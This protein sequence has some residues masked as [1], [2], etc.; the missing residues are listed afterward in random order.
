MPAPVRVLVDG[1]LLG[2]PYGF[3]RFAD[4]LCR[5]LGEAPVD[6]VEVTVVVPERLLSSL[7]EYPG[8]RWR[9]APETN[10]VRW[11][12]V[13]LPR[14]ARELRS[15]VLH[16]LY[17]TGPLRPG[18]ATV[19]TVHDLFFLHDRVPVRR[20]KDRIWAEY[21][22]LVFRSAIPRYAQVT[23]V[24][25]ATRRALAEVGIDARTVHNTVDGFVADHPP[26]V[27]P[28]RPRYALHRG[29]AM[30]HRNTQRVL[31][32]FAAVHAEVPDVELLVLGVPDGHTRFRVPDGLPVTFLPRISDQELADLYAG[33]AVVVATSLQEGFGLPVLEGFGFGSPVVTSTVE[34]L[35]EVAGDAALLVDPTDT[36]AVAHAVRRVLTEPGL[37]EHLVAA[38]RVR[39]ERF[40][41]A[42]AAAAMQD[43]YRQAARA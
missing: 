29:G 8:L 25:D 40:S 10:L 13:T 9:A 4:E 15:D 19:A 21:S 2:K 14:L 38:G 18:V 1:R 16:A 7:P 31:D 32:A 27:R 6:D 11:E 37:A 33:S 42:R 43:V 24:S 41:G 30:P 3:G 20:L 36:A 35:P 39:A 23:C 34:P 22:R 26:R 5:A 12:Q 28:D 17:N